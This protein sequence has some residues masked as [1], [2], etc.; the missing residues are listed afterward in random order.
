MDRGEIDVEG[1]LVIID[2]LT[3]SARDTRRGLALTPDE[4]VWRFD[5]LQER[6]W[7]AKAD[8]IVVCEIKPTQLADATYHNL[9]LHQYLASK[10]GSDGG[11]G[12]RTQV[13]LHHLRNDGLHLRPQCYA[14][15]QETYACIIMGQNVPSPTPLEGLIPDH[16]RLMREREWPRLSGGERGARA[17]NPNHGWTW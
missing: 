4:L 2:C 6:L 12:C 17:L 3:N 5:R 1:A 14:V 16:V 9:A 15:L 10:Q 13:R 11:H 7:T 8:G